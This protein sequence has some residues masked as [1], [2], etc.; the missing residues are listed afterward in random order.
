M[1]KDY[2]WSI[3]LLISFLFWLTV[4][5]YRLFFSY[6]IFIHV[7]VL[8]CGIR[9]LSF[10]FFLKSLCKKGDAKKQ[11]ALTFD[12]G[13]DPACTP[14]VLDLLDKYNFKATFFL[15]ADRV[16]RHRELCTMIAARG[17]T[18][19]CHDLHHAYTSNFRRSKKMT[20][21]IGQ[22]QSIIA[23][24]CGLKPR[25][26]RPPVGL[27]NPHLR[28]A[29][30]KNSM[31]CI[32]WSRSANDAGNRLRSSFSHFVSLPADGA[33]ILLHDVLPVAA[34]KNEY[35]SS[36][37]AMLRRLQAERFDVVTVDK[38]FSEKPYL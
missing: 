20:S 30:E 8:Y 7:I 37:E 31:I 32:G 25:F 38:L 13:P 15:I 18:I 23:L 16:L 21:E 27:S 36:L 9:Y 3:T 4:P 11:C 12:D 33:V 35:F 5:S 22:A 24:I 14:Q 1:R 29:L 26:Y 34:Y 10:N 28:T 19:A 2:I 17:H 6:I